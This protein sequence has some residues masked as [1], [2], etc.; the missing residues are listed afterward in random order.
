MKTIIHQGIKS[1]LTINSV[2]PL[3]IS[4]FAVGATQH[5]IIKEPTIYGGEYYYAHENGGPITKGFLSALALSPAYH[6]NC[7]FDSK[8]V[9]LM[10]GMYP[11]IPGW[12]CDEIKRTEGKI[13]CSKFHDND[14][15]A[16]FIGIVDFTISRTKFLEADVT[17]PY[18]ENLW[19][20]L[21]KFIET[22]AS[23]DD[24][25]F[26][27]AASKKIYRME[28][29]CIHTAQPAAQQ[30]WRWFGRLTLNTERNHTNELRK[31]CNIYVDV[32]NSG[33]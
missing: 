16:H 18:S 20:D 2:F 26:F 4:K 15:K 32:D 5:D 23:L 6:D 7:I 8:V 10:P 33:W 21:H 19:K 28:Y 1:L 30:G 3:P 9:Q 25:D 13:D 11:A 29:Q 22:D 24:A 17:L 12:H 31:Q 27:Y 14:S